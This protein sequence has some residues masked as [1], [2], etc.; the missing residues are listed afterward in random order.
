MKGDLL[1]RNFPLNLVRSLYL[2]WKI[3]VVNGGIFKREIP[4]KK[5]DLH[6][7][8]DN[9]LVVVIVDVFSVFCRRNFK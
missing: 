8:N 3:A 7:K 1:R 6:D 2:I 4:K 9:R 5:Q